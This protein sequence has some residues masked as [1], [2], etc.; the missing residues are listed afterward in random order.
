MLKR[1]RL[2]AIKNM[3]D[4]QGI[5]NV[6]DISKV[7]QVSLMT[8]RRDL[9]ELAGNHAIVRIHGGAQSL[10]YQPGTELTR[11]QKRNLNVTAKKAVAKLA[12]SL[13][14]TGDTVYIGPG[15]TN[16]WLADFIT[17]GDLH[18]ITNSLP[19]FQ[20]FLD[21]T[22]RFD[23]QLIGGSYR[24]RSGAFIG[25]LANEML[26]HL[27]TTKAFISANGVS[28]NAISNANPEEGQTQKIALD[29]AAARFVL[30]DPSKLDKQD[31]YQYYDLNQ[32]QGLITT[33]AISTT[34][35]EKYSQFTTVYPLA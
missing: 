35:R 20:S 25:S 9:D 17:A 33:K 22:E 7:L 19:I 5:A 26:T 2:V 14:Q 16:E 29:N 8:V 10:Q 3:I 23:L 1:E 11:M 15:T 31:F 32:M 21:K 13:I 30:A 34:T 4:Q 28:G 12:A 27:R 6:Q 24:A 18:I